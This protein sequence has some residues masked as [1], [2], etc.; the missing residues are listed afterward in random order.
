MHTFRDKN[1]KQWNIEL[2]VGTAKRAKSE[3]GI[4]LVNVIT[5][6]SDGKIEAAALER[7]ADDPVILVDCLF[8]LCREQAREAGLDDLGF[9]E[10]FDAAAVENASDALMEEII[11]FSRPAK[12]KTLEKIY[13][14][15]RRFAEKM[16]RKLDETLDS[17]EFE[18]E[19]ESELS[20]SFTDT[21]ESSE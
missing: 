12:R 7:L 11:N 18:A 10:L 16:D 17:P 19:I 9:A 13:Q 4:D 15:A 1:G 20:R 14:T 3:C 21:P 8:S 5:F 6:S 2:N